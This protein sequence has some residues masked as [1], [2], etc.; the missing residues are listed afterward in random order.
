PVRQVAPLLTAD[1]TT[2]L[3]ATT[4][5]AD[6][7]A[8]R[9]SARRDTALLLLGYAAALRRSELVALTIGDVTGHRTDGLHLRISRSRTDQ[10]GRG[11]TKAVPYGGAPAA[12]GP[13]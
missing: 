7:W 2:I 6:T 8:A 4:A 5:Q 11:T 12:C 13:C 3:A 10:D 9:V 1:I